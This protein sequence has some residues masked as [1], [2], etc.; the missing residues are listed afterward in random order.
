MGMYHSLLAQNR[1]AEAEKYK[2]RYQAAFTSADVKP[3]AS[4]F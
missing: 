4:V 1:K 2:Q 3:V